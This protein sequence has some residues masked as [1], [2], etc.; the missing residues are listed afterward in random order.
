MEYFLIKACVQ[1]ARGWCCKHFVSLPESCLF[2]SPL[3]PWVTAMRCFRSF[4]ALSE[5]ERWARGLCWV[6]SLLSLSCPCIL[7]LPNMLLLLRLGSCLCPVLHCFHWT[8]CLQFQS[9]NLCAEMW[10]LPFSSSKGLLLQCIALAAPFFFEVTVKC[11]VWQGPGRSWLSSRKWEEIITSKSQHSW[12]V[13]AECG[14]AEVGYETVIDCSEIRLMV[15]SMRW[16]EKNCLIVAAV[17][18]LRGTH[19]LRNPQM[20]PCSCLCM[21]QCILAAIHWQMRTNVQ[22]VLS[23]HVINQDGFLAKRK[24]A[25]P[26]WLSSP[27]M[28]NVIPVS[29]FP[30]PF[31]SLRLSSPF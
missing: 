25:W 22:Q 30:S 20:C 2:F 11:L 8:S 21:S 15:A 12:S 17:D 3:V 23:E 7:L 1:T 26:M 28:V 24:P 6:A 27:E 5:R 9:A 31:I 18:G 29:F 10:F 13:P 14:S 19:L 16:I 4:S